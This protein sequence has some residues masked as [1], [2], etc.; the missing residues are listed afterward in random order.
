VP[1]RPTASGLLTTMFIEKLPELVAL[2]ASWGKVMLRTWSNGLRSG[3]VTVAL[4]TLSSS[5]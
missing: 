3:K 1:E 5:N 4:V 2:R